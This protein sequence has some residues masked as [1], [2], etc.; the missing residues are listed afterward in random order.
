MVALR[1][2]F[3][4]QVLCENVWQPLVKALDVGR[5][6][7]YRGRCDD[8]IV[9]PHRVPSLLELLR[10]LRERILSYVRVHSLLAVTLLLVPVCRYRSCGG[11]D[12]LSPFP[13]HQLV[14]CPVQLTCAHSSGRALA[15]AMHRGSIGIMPNKERATVEL[16][17]SYRQARNVHRAEAKPPTRRW[18]ILDEAAAASS[19]PIRSGRRSHV[20]DGVQ[21]APGMVGA[22]L[23]GCRQC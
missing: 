18:S 11:S 5:S 10:V 19:P 2:S 20:R 12:L 13:L 21:W 7:V 17:R 15:F 16:T 9:H 8:M 6:V 4:P 14:A 22:Y 3:L 1:H 23:S